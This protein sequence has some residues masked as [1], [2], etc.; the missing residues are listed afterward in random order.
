M[1]CLGDSVHTGPSSAPQQGIL[2]G[3]NNSHKK[4]ISF[5]NAEFEKWVHKSSRV[6]R[7]FPTRGFRPLW[8]LRC[9]RGF[10]P[11][12]FLRVSDKSMIHR[13]T[14]FLVFLLTKSG[15]KYYNN[16]KKVAVRE[17]RRYQKQLTQSL[18]RNLALAFNI[19]APAY[20]I[21]QAR[22]PNLS[23]SFSFTYLLYMR[24]R[25]SA[26]GASCARDS[27]RKH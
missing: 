7:K 12:L 6:F 19:V 2:I 16:T 11:R 18:N 22:L 4:S 24:Q 9:K 25:F 27:A 8:I 5:Y 20:Y 15:G 13:K 26:V 1:L 17:H 14:I 10:Q 3:Y 23:G 21:C